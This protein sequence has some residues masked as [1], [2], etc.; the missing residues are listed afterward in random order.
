MADPVSVLVQYVG[1]A[2][3]VAL[4]GKRV[5]EAMKAKGLTQE[6]VAEAAH[7]S[8]TFVSD[9]IGGKAKDP[10]IVR[11]LRVCSSVGVELGSTI[12]TLGTRDAAGASGSLTKR[13]AVDDARLESPQ[14]Q[15]GSDALVTAVE[16]LARKVDRIEKRLRALEARGGVQRGTQRKATG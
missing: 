6:A 16:R 4:I 3:V 14:Q 13:R 12:A 9:L 7:V 8:Q 15:A 11:I 5:D 2:S 10:G 1:E